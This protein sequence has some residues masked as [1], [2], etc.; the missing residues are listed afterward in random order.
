[1]ANHNSNISYKSYT[2]GLFGLLKS[3]KKEISGITVFALL[4]GLVELTLP[5]GVQAIITYVM[6]G[7]VSTSLIFLITLV[8]AGVILNG[9]LHI[10]QLKIN[11]R[12]QQSLMV[13][14]GLHF[15]ASIPTKNPSHDSEMFKTTSYFMD[16]TVLQ[17]SLSKLMMDFPLAA[18]RIVT[19][20]IVLCFYHPLFILFSFFLIA[21]LW[22]IIRATGARGMESSIEES[23]YKYETYL[24]LLSQAL[25]IKLLRF[26][27]PQRVQLKDTDSKL[28]SY[29]KARNDHF[30]VLLLQYRSLILFKAL[31]TALML[32]AGSYLLIN[33][34]LSIGQ[35]IAA[36][37]LIIGVL[38]AV[39]KIITNMELVYDVLTALKKLDAMKCLSEEN[40]GKLQIETIHSIVVPDILPQEFSIKKGDK[41][42][43][44]G[45]LDDTA[46]SL[47][48]QISFS[49]F[50]K[51]RDVLVNSVPAHQYVHH[52]LRAKVAVYENNQSVMKGSILDNIRMGR[53]EINDEQ[54][55][56]IAEKT[57]FSQVV[58][59]LPKGY[60]TYVSPFD[61]SLSSE[62]Q[63]YLG[64]VRCLTGEKE[65]VVMYEPFLNLSLEEQILIRK[66]VANINS[67]VIIFSKDSTA[68]SDGGFMEYEF[69]S[70]QLIRKAK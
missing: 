7:F 38:G 60:Y 14:F 24:T 41:I 50:E 61:P 17:K 30:K 22:I 8:V 69:V 59:K 44:H 51:S 34:Q 10:S 63:Q 11:E 5:L 18:M 54:I 66:H 3:L 53:E 64:I 15:A 16:V 12:V 20:L 23:N 68:F 32:I 19:G 57:G 48:S 4:K 49:V 33:Q 36:E 26:F 35:F 21:L 70:D 43:I 2:D 58:N 52:T 39:E 65:M 37:I 42:W 28:S 13:R 62:L 46:K 67:T 40:D 29:L 47:F 55:I 25:H 56:S 45:D 31:L 9:G 1:M 6:G 27:A